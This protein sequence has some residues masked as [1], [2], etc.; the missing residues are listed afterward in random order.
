MFVLNHLELFIPYIDWLVYPICWLNLSSLYRGFTWKR[1]QS[2]LEAYM[3]SVPKNWQFLP[4]TINH[5]CWRV[6]SKKISWNDCWNSRSF[7]TIVLAL[8]SFWTQ[9]TLDVTHR[10]RTTVEKRSNERK[11]ILS[12]AWYVNKERDRKMNVHSLHIHL[13][14]HIVCNAKRLMHRFWSQICLFTSLTNERETRRF[15]CIR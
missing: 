8:P 7:W 9:R 11:N 2:R 10:S 4:R 1:A 6:C 3:I 15:V 5:L 13:D 14:D 12:R